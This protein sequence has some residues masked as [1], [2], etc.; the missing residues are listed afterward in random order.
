RVCDAHDETTEATLR[1]LREK[2]NTL[3]PI[4]RLPPE[5]LALVFTYL[6]GFA[7]D[8]VNGYPYHIRWIVVTHICRRWREVAI[9]HAGLWTNINLDIGSNWAATFASRARQVLLAI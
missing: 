5:V 3:I 2:R 6:T 4:C 7:W 8:S 1:A 9:Q